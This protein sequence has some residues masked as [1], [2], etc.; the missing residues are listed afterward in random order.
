MGLRG[1][2]TLLL[3]TIRIMLPTRVS[4]VPIAYASYLAGVITMFR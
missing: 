2:Q 1:F 4:T 3:T